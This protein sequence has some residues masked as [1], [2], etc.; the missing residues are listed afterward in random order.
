MMASS[1]TS[2]VWRFED[3]SGGNREGTGHSFGPSFLERR[4]VGGSGGIGSIHLPPPGPFPDKLQCLNIA[5]VSSA[6]CRAAYPGRITDN[7]LCAGGNMGKDACQVS[8]CRR[9]LATGDREQGAEEG[10]QGEGETGK[11]GRGER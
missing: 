5:I 7:M 1:H 2:K 4:E 8:R 10:G 11:G 3:Y 6:T 9:C